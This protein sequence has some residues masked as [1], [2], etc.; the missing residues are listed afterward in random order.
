MTPKAQYMKEN[1]TDLDFG[2]IKDFCSV[3][4][5]LRECC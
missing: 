5:V 3:N 1:I 2:K 4:I